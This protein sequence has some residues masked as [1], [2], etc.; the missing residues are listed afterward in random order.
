MYALHLCTRIYIN[1]QNSNAIVEE[2]YIGTKSMTSQVF[3]PFH[4]NFLVFFQ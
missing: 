1:N 2:F 4:Q 3:S